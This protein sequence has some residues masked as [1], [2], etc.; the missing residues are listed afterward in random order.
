MGQEK[1]WSYPYGDP[2]EHF[3]VPTYSCRVSG[4]DDSGGNATQTFSVVRFGLQCNDGKT[5]KV[6]GLAD[7]QTHVIKAWLPSYRVHSGHS[8]ENGA[9]QVYNNFLIHDGRD[10]ERDDIFAS[11]GC[12]EIRG[13][14]GFSRFNDFILSLAGSKASSREGQL[15]EIGRS[16]S[17][18]ITYEQAARPPVVRV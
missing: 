13:V 8:M 5:V 11:I 17:M 1:V 10:N 9:W 18:F 14:R 2:S 6:V 15:G 7:P 16:G 3:W 12:I 4:T